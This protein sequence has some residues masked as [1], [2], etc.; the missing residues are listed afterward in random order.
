MNISKLTITSICSQYKKNDIMKIIEPSTQRAAD[1]INERL[2]A[3]DGF[4]LGDGLPRF[5][6]NVVPPNKILKDEFIPTVDNYKNP[7]G[8]FLA[9]MSKKLGPFLNK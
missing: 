7:I 4:Y 1:L 2:Y 9:K 8:T 5:M 6:S 3:R